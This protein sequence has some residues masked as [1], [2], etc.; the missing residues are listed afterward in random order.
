MKQ[1]FLSY[2]RQDLSIVLEI[3]DYLSQELGDSIWFDQKDIPAASD[4][5][6]EIKRGLDEC[7]SLLLIASSFSMTSKNVEDEWR[8]MLNAGGRVYVWVIA[9]CKIDLALQNSSKS[10]FLDMR[11]DPCDWVQWKIGKDQIKKSETIAFRSLNLNTS[12]KPSYVRRYTSRVLIFQLIPLIATVILGIAGTTP[13]CLS[14]LFSFFLIDNVIVISQL[15]RI[16]IRAFPSYQLPQF[17]VLM[18]MMKLYIY[19]LLIVDVLLIIPTL[20]F[21][22]LLPGGR[23]LFIGLLL[24]IVGGCALIL[25]LIKRY[26]IGP[27]L[28]LN[29]F[30]GKDALFD[31]IV[32]GH[33]GRVLTGFAFY[34]VDY[35]KKYAQAPQGQ[36]IYQQTKL[37]N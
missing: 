11:K 22:R 17:F 3:F 18:F 30:F 9:D 23:G 33:G 37:Y 35:Y 4:W 29:S 27:E 1:I 8:T 6:V 10:S 13:G 34:D 25:V 14:L 31:Y 7:K 26:Q 28:F 15:T 5:N 19:P 20:L 12:I 36:I 2:A 21:D 24:G 16:R 32:D